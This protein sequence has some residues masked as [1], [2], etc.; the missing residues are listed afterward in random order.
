V[1]TGG[2]GGYGDPRRR[3]AAA[4]QRDLEH[5]YVTATPTVEFV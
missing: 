3:S 5:G 4:T 1:M 2:G